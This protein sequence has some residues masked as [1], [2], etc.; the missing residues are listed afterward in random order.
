MVKPPDSLMPIGKSVSLPTGSDLKSQGNR[1][2]KAS[3]DQQKSKDSFQMEGRVTASDSKR[4]LDDFSEI[5]KP[6]EERKPLRSNFSDPLLTGGVV[7]VANEAERW[8]ELLDRHYGVELPLAL[9]ERIAYAHNSTSSSL[10]P[11]KIIAPS[12]EELYHDIHSRDGNRA[13]DIVQRSSIQIVAEGQTLEELLKDHYC[14]VGGL[15]HEDLDDDFVE[16]A[17][18]A[19]SVLNGGNRYTGKPLVVA[20]PSVDDLA[21][22]VDRLR[23]DMSRMNVRRE[24]WRKNQGSVDSSP[25]E[26]LPPLASSRGSSPSRTPS[27][28]N[29]KSESSNSPPVVRTN[30]RA[31]GEV[32][33]FRFGDPSSLAQEPQITGIAQAGKYYQPELGEKMADVAAYVYR[34][35]LTRPGV[36]P[37]EA[38]K[39]LQEIMLAVVRWNKLKTLDIGHVPVV[40]WPSVA[41]LERFMGHPEVRAGAEKLKLAA[42]HLWQAIVATSKDS[43]VRARIAQDLVVVE[44]R[45]AD[46][47]L[48]AI[49]HAS[50]IVY[51]M[52]LEQMW[53][54]P[55]FW[56]LGFYGPVW[57]SNKDSGLGQRVA[58]GELLARKPNETFE[59][60]AR[61]LFDGVLASYEIAEFSERPEFLVAVHL[62]IMNRN[63]E[64][65]PGAKEELL[66]GL[67]K[68]GLVNDNGT[69]LVG[70]DLN[71]A[72]IDAKT[73]AIIREK[74]GINIER[75]P[76]EPIDEFLVRASWHARSS[77]A[78]D[79]IKQLWLWNTMAKN[80]VQTLEVVDNQSGDS[81][82]LGANALDF[83]YSHDDVLDAYKD[84]LMLDESLWADDAWAVEPKG[85]ASEEVDLGEEAQAIWHSTRLE[86]MRAGIELELMTLAQMTEFRKSFKKLLEYLDQ[87]ERETA[88][89]HEKVVIGARV[90]ANRILNGESV[91]APMTW[92]A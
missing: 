46:E 63:G 18:M 21:M 79:A 66:A 54:N 62:G 69:L 8:T 41:Q 34:D 29:T 85:S 65:E 3:V 15:T 75:E 80:G 44:N 82:G 28:A 12:L 24:A 35:F 70:S 52:Q 39:E 4:P 36:T 78:Q 73:V 81:I 50:D 30:I 31:D 16:I 22:L 72:A 83:L 14:G 26:A 20:L 5:S 84:M 38:E 71:A 19:L 10:P 92:F 88:E 59:Q 77:Q 76:G 7:V 87:V 60:Y 90:C 2:L 13:A 49:Q 56:D 48:K 58:P 37:E 74:L 6:S 86:L 33:V 32:G 57:D 25:Q 9:V 61:R 55:D 91:G 64:F 67:L 11:D 68:F 47:Q 1:P 23:S 53:S 42:P 89:F 43:Q 45:T 51:S 40:Y 27:S 17:L